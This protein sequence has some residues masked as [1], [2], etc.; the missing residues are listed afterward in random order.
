MKNRDENTTIPQL[1]Y[2][3]FTI[4]ETFFTVES[5]IVVQYT[6]PFKGAFIIYQDLLKPASIR[7]EILFEIEHFILDIITFQ[8]GQ[9]GI[10]DIGPD[11]FITRIIHG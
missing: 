7:P 8:E 3:T 11:H 10:L 4:F 5:E 2:R 1:S 6:S 9:N